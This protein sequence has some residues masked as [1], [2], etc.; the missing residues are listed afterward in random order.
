MHFMQLILRVLNNF[1]EDA[2]LRG[3]SEDKDCP[4]NSAAGG[5]THMGEL[6][7]G[8]STRQPGEELCVAWLAYLP[9][10]ELLTG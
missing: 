4:A 1:K 9:G 2:N 6:R 7:Q 10:M 8:K 3:L 5:Q